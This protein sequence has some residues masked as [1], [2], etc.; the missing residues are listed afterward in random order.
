MD[1]L[2]PRGTREPSLDAVS[3]MSLR[4]IPAESK[5]VRGVTVSCGVPGG[6]AP[7]P[8][9]PRMATARLASSRVS[10]TIRCSSL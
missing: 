7:A 6:R 1:A 9:R 8:L 3:D 10:A 5:L 4:L 2:I